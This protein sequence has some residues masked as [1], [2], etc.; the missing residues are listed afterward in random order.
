[1]THTGSP[2]KPESAMTEISLITISFSPP[3]PSA[4]INA[5]MI[6]MTGNDIQKVTVAADAMGMTKSQLMRILLVK[7]AERILEE[8]GVTIEYIQ[9][10]TIDLSKG[11]TLI[12]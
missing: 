7:G 8:L 3:H 11:E 6:R 1:M 2:L 5:Q 9:N 12:E 4:G 10:D